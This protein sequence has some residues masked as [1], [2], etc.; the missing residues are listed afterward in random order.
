M[1]NFLL[2]HIS[3]SN[4]YANEQLFSFLERYIIMNKIYKRRE[5]IL[6]RPLL[7]Y[8]YY[9]WNITHFN[10]EE[11]AKI[12]IKQQEDTPNSCFPLYPSYVDKLEKEIYPSEEKEFTEQEHQENLDF[13]EKLQLDL[14]YVWSYKQRLESG[15]S[16]LVKDYKNYYN[17]D[18]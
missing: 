1:K 8:K 5:Y 18:N 15:M 3:C 7:T 17:L 4:N 16:N 13:L 14:E 12:A 6:K 10:I 2:N 9:A 11:W